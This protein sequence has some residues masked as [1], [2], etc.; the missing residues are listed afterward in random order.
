M[1][2]T[3]RLAGK[4]VVVTGAARGLGRDYARYFAMDGA[5]VVVADVKDTTGAA[6][7]ASAIGPR[8]IGLECDVTSQA[9]VDAMVAATVSEFGR[10]D[11]LINNAGLWRGLAEAGLLECPDDV[12][13][14]A[15]N[16]NVTGTLRA[17][18]AAVPAMKANSWGR[19]I[20]V[21]SMAAKSG[22]NSYGLTKATVEHMT[23]GLARELGDFGITVNCIAPGISAFEAAGSQLANADQITGSNPIKRFGTSR[24]QYEAMAYFCSDGADYTTGQTL[25]VDGGA[26][27]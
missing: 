26:T 4:V 2:N 1:T 16:V 14:I 21:S 25:Y 15:W 6:A 7:E 5:H 3:N 10:L 11:I 23:R 27:S 19:I 8:C 22:G 12:W 24:E 17:S 20:N 18:R 9:S 13:D